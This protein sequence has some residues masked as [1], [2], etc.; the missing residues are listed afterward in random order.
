M[1][2]REIVK[3]K[4]KETDEIEFQI[5]NEKGDVDKV[6]RFKEPHSTYVDH[7]LKYLDQ[8]LDRLEAIVRKLK[9]R[10]EG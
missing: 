9:R 4:L 7:W 6:F 10:L 5:R 1:N 2:K 8:R 3:R